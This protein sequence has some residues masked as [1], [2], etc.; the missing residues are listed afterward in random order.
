MILALMLFEII[1]T[2]SRK[3]SDTYRR[4]GGNFTHNVRSTNLFD[5][6]FHRIRSQ[7][8]KQLVENVVE[9]PE[10]QWEF[11]WF[12]CYSYGKKQIQL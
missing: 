11:W 3:L 4:R 12:Y 2:R 5:K 7:N 8:I 1:S 6:H 9:T 10:F